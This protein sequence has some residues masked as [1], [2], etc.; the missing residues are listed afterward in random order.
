ML[1]PVLRSFLHWLR[2]YLIQYELLSILL[3]P[4]L[5]SPAQMVR[6]S[7]SAYVLCSRA[8][9][10]PPLFFH[11]LLAVAQP[12]GWHNGLSVEGLGFE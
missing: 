8:R 10:W 12:A 4:V 1:A 3:F 7:S 9:T 6:L 5:L 11:S 2:T